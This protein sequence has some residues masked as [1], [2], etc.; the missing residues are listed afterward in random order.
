[1]NMSV[2]CRSPKISDHVGGS[3]SLFACPWG[4]IWWT[5][6]ANK[7][8]CSIRRQIYRCPYSG[9]CHRDSRYNWRFQSGDV[10]GVEN[11][12]E[13]FCI[14]IGLVGLRFFPR[15]ELYQRLRC[16]PSCSSVNASILAIVASKRKGCPSSEFSANERKPYPS[17]Q[18]RGSGY[19]SEHTARVS[20][21]ERKENTDSQEDYLKLKKWL[22]WWKPSFFFPLW[23]NLNRIG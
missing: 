19:P 14:C 23:R 1:M 10:K 2:S 21:D 4:I 13:I 7:T 16:C 6:Y 17:Y 5:F 9:R 20:I 8:T 12:P 18:K 11:I 3:S 22:E 15:Y